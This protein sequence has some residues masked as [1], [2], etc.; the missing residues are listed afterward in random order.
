MTL[1]NNILLITCLFGI[2][3]AVCTSSVFGEQWLEVSKEQNGTITSI[4]DDRVKISSGIIEFWTSR[5]YG[6]VD[7]ERD[8]VI[9]FLKKL[10]KCDNCETLYKT[11]VL[12]EIRCTDYM[13]RII[14]M[15]HYNNDGRVLHQMNMQH[16]WSHII[17]GTISNFVRSKYCK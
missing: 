13:Y 11:L 3:L 10:N 12:S 5:I 9:A 1:R 7:R 2:N 6:D 14:E 4:D 16:G 8:Y 15:I 17:P